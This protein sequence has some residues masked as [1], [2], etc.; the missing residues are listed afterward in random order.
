MDGTAKRGLFQRGAKRKAGRVDAQ[1][2]VRIIPSS[3][4]IQF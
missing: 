1:T 2:V 4:Y 3:G